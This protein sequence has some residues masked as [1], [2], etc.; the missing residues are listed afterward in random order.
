[1]N[2]NDLNYWM[3]YHEV[4]HMKRQGCSIRKICEQLVMNF[5]TVSKYLSMSEDEFFKHLE[6]QGQRYRK[7]APYEEFVK[8]RLGV[9]PE[10]GAAQMHDWLKERH[11]G[12]PIVCA[13]TIFNFVVYIRQKYNIPQEYEPRQYFPVEELEYGKQ[14]QVDFGECTLRTVNGSRKKVYFF[15]MVLSR[16]RQKYVYYSSQPFTTQ[17]AIIAHEKAFEYFH[18]I[19]Q[20]LVYDQD[21][22]F[23]HDENWGDL[24]LTRE[25]KAYTAPRGISLFFCRKQDAPSK[26]KIENV[27]RYIKQNFLYNRVFVDTDTLNDQGLEWLSRTANVMVHNRTRKVPLHEWH[28]EKNYLRSYTPILIDFNP[29]DSRGVRKTNEISFQG[30]CY[31]V[32]EGTYQGKDTEVMVCIQD[33]QLWIYSTGNTFICKHPLC[34]EKGKLIRNTDHK[35]DK[36]STIV[37]LLEEVAGLFGSPAEVIGYLKELHQAKPRYIRD[38]LIVIRGAVKESGL[39]NVYRAISYCMEKGIYQATSLKTM[40]ENYAREQRQIPA[41]ST[42]IIKLLPRPESMV[43]A[44]IKPLT[45]NI[46]DYEQLIHLKKQGNE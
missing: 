26:G 25:F 30:N 37:Q 17:I 36:S 19:P 21:K 45:S 2:K 11:P 14:A 35:R 33:D 3:M 5:R 22:L 38:Q 39:E 9:H 4:H 20:E 13:K 43:K 23:L 24:L 42:G 27:I 32:P 28:I 1:M 12:F 6:S 7:L 18:G 31:T 40:A 44:S 15:S 29:Y 34:H 16:S 46:A 41:E 10:T 8:E